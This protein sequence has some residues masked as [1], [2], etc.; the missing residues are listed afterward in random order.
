MLSGGIESIGCSN[1][2]EVKKGS[3]Q[4]CCGDITA[5]SSVKLLDFN[6]VWERIAHI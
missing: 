4:S 5:V 3:L 6:M 2:T 1:N